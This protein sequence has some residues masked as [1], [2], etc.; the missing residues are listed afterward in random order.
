MV[1]GK[2]METQIYKVRD[3]SGA[4]RE[5]KGPIGADDEMVIAK[6]KELFG[7]VSS[8]DGSIRTNS[9][10]SQIPTEAGANLM[11]TADAPISMRDRI[12][13]IVETPL[14]LGANIATSIPLFLAGV[15]GLDFQRKVANEIQY[16]PRT[17]T[18][19]DALEAVASGINA[20][21]LPPIIGG[22]L[23]FGVNALAGPAM[24]QTA[25]AARPVV[26]PGKH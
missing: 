5:I 25:A 22:G 23:G 26:Y 1:G 10:A 17:Q 12:S 4:I 11:P 6:A 8:V 7:A 3:P 2:I 21:K 14:A 20:L 15:G 19:R 16:Q 13:G 18:A 24:R 9:A